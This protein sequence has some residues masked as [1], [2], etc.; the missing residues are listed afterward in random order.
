MYKYNNMRSLNA[1]RNLMYVYFSIYF[2]KYYYRNKNVVSS[3]K[4]IF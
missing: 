3:I 2:Q 4:F 1:I